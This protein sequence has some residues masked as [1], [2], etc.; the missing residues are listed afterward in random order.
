MEK[1]YTTKKKIPDAIL[2]GFFDRLFNWNADLG[3]K[4]DVVSDVKGFT[5]H[6]PPGDESLIFI[7]SPQ[8]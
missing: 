7:S 3:G 1:L 2:V 5:Q 4:V 6:R 8:F